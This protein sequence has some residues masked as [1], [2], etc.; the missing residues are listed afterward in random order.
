MS[1]VGV[2]TWLRAGICKMTPFS[3]VEAS[4]VCWIL[5]C[6]LCGGLPLHTLIS[7][8]GRLEVVAARSELTLRSLES[9]TN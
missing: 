9:L 7:R 4:S 2:S 8:V 3:I 1:L 5:R 6:S